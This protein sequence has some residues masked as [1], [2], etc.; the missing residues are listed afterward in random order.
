MY[1]SWKTLLWENWSKLRHVEYLTICLHIYPREWRIQE[2]LTCHANQYRRDIQRREQ[3]KMAWKCAGEKSCYYTIYCSSLELKVGRSSR[4]W[5]KFTEIYTFIL[6]TR[7]QGSQTTFWYFPGP[8]YQSK[9]TT[10]SQNTL[11]L[12]ETFRQLYQFWGLKSQK[13]HQFYYM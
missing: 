10:F 2:N 4:Y 7:T 9:T 3:W 11:T 5:S 6:Q 1:Y 13:S 8:Q 12:I